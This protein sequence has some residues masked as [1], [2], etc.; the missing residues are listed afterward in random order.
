MLAGGLGFYLPDVIVNHL[1]KKR[2]ESIFLACP[3]RST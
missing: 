1:K 2:A 3:T